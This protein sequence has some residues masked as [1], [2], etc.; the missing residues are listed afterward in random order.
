MS[1]GFSGVDPQDTPESDGNSV[2]EG[3]RPPHPAL[4]TRV[5]PGFGLSMGISLTY[6]SL[7]ILLPLGALAFRPWQDGWQAGIKLFSE[8]LGDDRVQAALRLSF[9]L[10]ALAALVN[11]I[12][13]LGIAWVLTRYRFAWR[14]LLDAL[15]DLPFALP[16]AVAGIA[17]SALYGPHGW[18]G[19]PLMAYEIKVAYTPLGIFIA[20][21][22]VGLPFIVRTLEPVLAEF[23]RE[24]EEAAKTLGAHP[25]QTAWRVIIPSLWPAMISGFTLAFARAVGEYGSVIFI[26]GNLPKISEIAPLL[27]VI[28]LEEYDLAGAST[29]ALIML[30]LSFVI[31][32]IGNGLQSWLTRRISA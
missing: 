1:T 17:L 3:F 29:V 19:A 18:M 12:T 9:S 25:L 22:F 6:I 31:L 28:K 2:P 4:H 15:I 10:A 21:V 24:A 32:A 13:G 11:L 20:L 16:T 30:G 7:M 14:R 8:T 26:A 5:L 23:D 27:I